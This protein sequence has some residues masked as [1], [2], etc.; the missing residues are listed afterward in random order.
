MAG[1]KGIKDVVDSELQGRTRSGWW[2]KVS[3]Q[4]T[5]AGIWYDLATA[6]GNPKAKNWFDAAPLK[7]TQAS[8]SADIGI[9]HGADVSPSQK[10]IRET[11]CINPTITSLPMPMMLLDY[12]LYYPTID[13]AETGAQVMD[14]SVTLPRYTDGKGVQMMAVTL[15]TRTGGQTFTVTYTNSDGVAGRTSQTVIQ[16]TSTA[17][18]TITTSS[19]TVNTGTGSPFIG[20]QSGDKGVRSIQ[21]VQMNGS[22]TG[23]F[24]IILVKPLAETTIREITA[25]VEVDYL[26]NKAE[27][28]RVYDD[29]F[30]GYICMPNGTLSGTTLMGNVK[31]VWN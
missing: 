4:T 23:L 26:L 14:N 17:L 30:L 20:L 19:F 22:D 27:L 13:D 12:L 10:H 21:S 6:P 16:N 24:A 15:A 11:V 25:P 2:R 28:P 8:Q 9:Y 1:F 29:A 31:V 5:T 7:A 18:G 3:T